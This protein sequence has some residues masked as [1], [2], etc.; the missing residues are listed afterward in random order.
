M[1]TLVAASGPVAD[2]QGVPEGVPP[3]WLTFVSVPSLTERRETAV[4]LGATVLMP[5]IA[6]PGIGLI[7]VIQDPTGGVIG[8]FEPDRG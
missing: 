7:G 2:L 8:L 5:E 4:R 1:T 6:V 3:N